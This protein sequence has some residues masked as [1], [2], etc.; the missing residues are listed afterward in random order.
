MRRPQTR[1]LGTQT[2]AEM[3]EDMHDLQLPS[4][5]SKAPSHPGESK[6]GKLHADQWRSL[7]TIN[8]PVTLIRLWGS[9]PEESRER[10]M[11]TNF[12]HLVTALKLASMRIM[13]EKRIAQ[14]EHEMRQYLVTLLELFPGTEIS[15]YQHMALHLGHQL[16]KFGPTHAVRCFA[17]ERYNFLMQKIPTN[18]IYGASF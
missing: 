16:R 5:V 11:L 18:T 8:L 12:M 15:P 14:Y 17:F 1:V 7:C 4:W 3:R 13:T 9:K 6:W 2:T 10:R